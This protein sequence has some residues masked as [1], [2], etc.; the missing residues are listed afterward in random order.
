MIIF[1]IQAEEPCT[2]FKKCDKQKN[3]KSNLFKIKTYISEYSQ[4][5]GL[6]M[7]FQSYFLY[8]QHFSTYYS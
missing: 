2:Q 7:Q 5:I 1:T 8:Y 4:K 3:Y 6:N